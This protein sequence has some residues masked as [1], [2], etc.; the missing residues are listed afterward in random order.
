M[1]A[2]VEIHMRL[3]AGVGRW[4]SPTPTSQKTLLSCTSSETSPRRR[5]MYVDVGAFDPVF[6]SNT[7]IG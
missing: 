1:N 5:G 7:P 3:G 6:H 2:T 4:N